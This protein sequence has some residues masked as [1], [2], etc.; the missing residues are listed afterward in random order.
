M[1]DTQTEYTEAEWQES[2][3]HRPLEKVDVNQ[4]FLLHRHWIW[5]NLQ[6]TR[7]EE[8]F[9]A[10]PRPDEGAFLADECWA[11]MLLWYALLWS[12]IEGFRDREIGLRGPFAQ[13]IESYADEMRRSRNVV[14]HVSQK[15]QHDERLYGLMMRPDS[16]G[17]LRRISTGFGRL[18]I[19]E[20]QARKAEGRIGNA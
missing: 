18:F 11:S 1:V 15:N 13:D 3:G 17:A 2:A 9:P 4:V 19:E 10:A 14:F 6:R 20:A 5:A 16:A 12:V 8:T 7:F